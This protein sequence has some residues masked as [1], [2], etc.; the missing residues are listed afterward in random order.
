[1][2]KY[3]IEIVCL[4][5][6]AAFCVISITG[7]IFTLDELPTRFMVALLGAIITSVITLILFHGRLMAEEVK[8]RNIKIFNKKSLLFEK[9]YNKLNKIIV[10]KELSA[11]D[12]I[13]IKSEFCSKL[14]F[15][16]KEKTRNEI[17]KYLKEL[18]DYA[19]ISTNNDIFEPLENNN[20]YEKSIGN[21]FN[22]INALISDIGLDG[23]INIDSLREL[24]NMMFSGFF[25]ELIVEEVNKIFLNEK[26]FNNAHY[27]IMANGTFLV[28]GLK[29][30]YTTGG[31]IHIGPFFNYTANKDFPAYD[32]LYF[33]F[34]APMLNPVSGSYTVNDGTNYNK[35]LI[36]FEGSKNGLID[37]REK[38][39][40]RTFEVKNVDSII[41]NRKLDTIRFDDIKTI[42]KY[43]NNRYE[44]VAKAIA[45]RTHF[46][47]L[48]AR[49][50][51]DNLTIIDLYNKF[52][53]ITDEQYSE[54]IIKTLNTSIDF[55]K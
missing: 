51:K 31:G 30:K 47:F 9:F 25:K 7:K 32:G 19:E 3:I 54:H 12:F 39:Q 33:R 23:K 18:G 50:K 28:L 48:N 41:Y 29:G 17:V 5:C 21:I 2:P 11:N 6:I 43:A 20:W 53:N 38:L 35:A 4:I 44:D 52:E 22:I 24:D 27:M 37:L 13:D 10:T 1:M 46:Y 42:R 16:V 14:I 34:F 36:D 45:A 26:I 15:Y 49:T 40:P 8:E 55:S